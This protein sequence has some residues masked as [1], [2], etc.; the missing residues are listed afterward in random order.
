MIDNDMLLAFREESL[1]IF[2]ELKN[3]IDMLNDSYT[4]FPMQ[5][6]QDFS[7]KIDRIMGAAKTISIQDPNHQGLQR[8]GILGELCKHI[9][10]KAAESKQLTLLPIFAAFYSDVITVT[11]DLLA[12]LEDEKRAAKITSD[13]APVLIKRLE[14]LKKKII[15]VPN[16]TSKNEISQ[17]E[18]DKL[19]SNFLK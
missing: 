1:S 10:Y 2:T 7:Q 18:I 3:I 12:S 14:W 16:V 19:V 11:E 15:S 13:F 6:L 8:I 5:L 9:G 4:E 17:S